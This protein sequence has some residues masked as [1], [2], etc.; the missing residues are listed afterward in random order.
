VRYASVHTKKSKRSETHTLRHLQAFQRAF[1]DGQ[2]WVKAMKRTPRVGD[3][4]GESSSHSQT[5]GYG[6]P[7]CSVD[8]PT[9]PI[10]GRPR[11]WP[12]HCTGSAVRISET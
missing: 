7:V 2:N 11:C 4:S 9:L 1:G 10:S 12:I 8:V 5:R 6:T 3:L